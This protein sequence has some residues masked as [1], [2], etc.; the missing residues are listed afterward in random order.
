MMNNRTALLAR[1]PD[2]RACACG[3][4]LDAALITDPRAVPAA[5]RQRLALLLGSRLPS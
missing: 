5:T 1:L 4:A 2:E 3:R